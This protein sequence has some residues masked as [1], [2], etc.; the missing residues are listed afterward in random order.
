M[1][2]RRDYPFLCHRS[3]AAVKN[4]Q[5]TKMKMRA[6][7]VKMMT[8]K[9]LVMMTTTMTKNRSKVLM[10]TCLAL[11]EKTSQIAKTVAL[12]S[13]MTTTKMRMP[14]ARATKLLLTSLVVCTLLTNPPRSLMMRRIMTRDQLAA[15]M[16][17]LVDLLLLGG[18]M[19]TT[20]LD[21]EI[22]DGEPVEQVHLIVEEATSLER[23]LLVEK[24]KEK[25]MDLVQ[26]LNP[27]RTPAQKTAPTSPTK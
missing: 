23:Q 11:E 18:E 25:T 6:G 15:S 19:P 10:V 27:T 9:S 4:R 1:F 24:R 3:E 17:C 21:L 20:R 26:H 13:M 14:L 22:R 2:R 8:T 7:S 5:T 16:I 12:G